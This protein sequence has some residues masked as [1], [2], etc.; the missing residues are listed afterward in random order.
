MELKNEFN[1]LK[2]NMPLEYNIAQIGPYCI[3][4]ENVIIEKNVIL[5]SNVVISGRTT[6]GEGTKV[7]PFT[8]LGGDYQDIDGKDQI[9]LHVI[10][11]NNNIIVAYTRLFT[12]LKLED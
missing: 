6:V 7:W 11:K 1:S 8:V 3:I 5:L 12:E 4:G 2:T 10:G 9:S